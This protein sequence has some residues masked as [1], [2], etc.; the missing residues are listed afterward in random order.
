MNFNEIAPKS[1]YSKKE[2]ISSILQDEKI[3]KIKNTMI[4]L[5]MAGNK[6]PKF[7]FLS[8]TWKKFPTLEKAYNCLK[9]NQKHDL[10]IFSKERMKNGEIV[11]SFILTNIDSFWYEY[12]QL[13]PN[14]RNFYEVII[15]DFPA[16]LYLD[17]EFDREF[18]TITDGPSLTSKF[19]NF[20]IE[21]IFM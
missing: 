10:R 3:N 9:E 19:I 21:C 5:K 12:M 2:N 20:L 7:K 18:N 6:A 16:K 13:K 14:Y 4:E 15:P 1:F 8:Y 11:F 17:L